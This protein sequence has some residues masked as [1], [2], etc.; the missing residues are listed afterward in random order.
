MAIRCLRPIPLHSNKDSNYIGL[1]MIDWRYIWHRLIVFQT[2]ILLLLLSPCTGSAETYDDLVAMIQDSAPSTQVKAKVALAYNIKKNVLNMDPDQFTENTFL[3]GHFINSDAPDLAVGISVPPREG[4]LVILSKGNNQYIPMATVT[5]IAFIESM[6]S[7][8]LFPCP[9]E[10]IVL[11]LFGGGSGKQHWG[12]D[13]YRWD[14]TKMRMIWAWVR[15][16][17][18]VNWPPGPKGIDGHFVR[19]ESSIIASGD[20]S[21]K[22]IHTSSVVD[23]GVFSRHEGHRSELEE[24]T[25]HVE[26]REV[27]RW[28]DALYY[29]VAKHGEILSQRITVT[30]QEGIPQKEGSETLVGGRVVGILDIPSVH[31]TTDAAYHIVIGKEHFC[32]VPKSAVRILEETK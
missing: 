5:G 11:N 16:D 3:V 29:Y 10:Q 17:I 31:H 12:K 30:C 19:S 8:K 7:T 14:G 20:C 21:P 24:V 27:H 25:S 28:D 15:K 23:V 13:I 9:L 18:A 32:E 2:A 26:R 1:I 22:E 6:E 4:N